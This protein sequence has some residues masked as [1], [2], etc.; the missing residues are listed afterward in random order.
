[1]TG[2]T[3]YLATGVIFGDF[4]F[5]VLFQCKNDNFTVRNGIV[6]RATGYYY[7]SPN[8]ITSTGGNIYFENVFFESNG[9]DQFL[10]KHSQKLHIT[11][12]RSNQQWDY[13]KS[14]IYFADT[15]S[16]Y[17]SNSNLELGNFDAA[18]TVNSIW[19][20]SI[21]GGEIMVDNSI[22]NGASKMAVPTGNGLNSLGAFDLLYNGSFNRIMISNSQFTGYTR[23]FISSTVL[24]RT[25]L[26][27]LDLIAIDNCVVNSS[28]FCFFYTGAGKGFSC[29]N[30]NVSNTSFYVSASQIYD[31]IYSSGSAGAVVSFAPKFDSCYFKLEA[32]GYAIFGAPSK[33]SNSIFTSTAY[34]Y[35]TNRVDLDNCTFINSTV[36]IAPTF[37]LLYY[38]NAGIL[39]I[40]NVNFPSNPGAVFAAFGGSSASGGILAEAKSINGTTYYKVF[41]IGSNIAVSGTFYKV[42]GVYF[43]RG[44]DYYIPNGSL[45]Q[46]THL[47]TV[48]KVT[49]NLATT[50]T[51]AAAAGATSITVTSAT[52]IATGDKLNVLCDNGLVSTVTVG[53]Y[54]SGLTIP[55]SALG[56]AAANGSKINFF[57][58]V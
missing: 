30:V 32:A 26:A 53:S 18:V 56:F 54:S 40:D 34:R 28:A 58:V 31:F 49:F 42:N 4:S 48:E 19:D 45:I 27:T 17:I 43:L 1:M 6:N 11:N 46:D 47:G 57:R 37:D 35:N 20:G 5:N 15:G 16:L 38:G 51:A 13:A 52:G 44:D 36:S 29:P 21:N 10:I 25:E 50:L 39:T 23:Y 9:T 2:S 24:A 22:I 55:I 3:D 33:V 7:H 14:G 8:A 41:K 12:C